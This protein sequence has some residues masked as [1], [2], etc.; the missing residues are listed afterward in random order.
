M[1]SFNPGIALAALVCAA[2]LSQAPV[3]AQACAAAGP[4]SGSGVGG[5][6]IA[7]PIYSL[8]GA[9]PD[10]ECQFMFR[11]LV[12]IGV[13]PGSS[14]PALPQPEPPIYIGVSLNLAPVVVTPVTNPPAGYQWDQM[15]QGPLACGSFVTAVFSYIPIGGSNPVHLGTINWTCTACLGD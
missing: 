14:P 11:A 6:V 10:T 15:I 8:A 5:T 13:V 3:H 2:L 12:V 9:C 7:Q 4:Y 1:N